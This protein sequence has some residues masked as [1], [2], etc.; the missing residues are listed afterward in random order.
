MLAGDAAVVDRCR[1]GHLGGI[2][3]RPPA[4]GK[5]SYPC[6]AGGGSSGYQRALDEEM[7]EEIRHRGG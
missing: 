1:R 6:R 3:K 5:R 7:R 2:R 4:A